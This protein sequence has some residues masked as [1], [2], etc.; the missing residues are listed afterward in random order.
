MKD[1][2]VKTSKRHTYILN[3]TLLLPSVPPKALQL[4]FSKHPK[5]VIWVKIHLSL[6]TSTSLSTV[7]RKPLYCSVQSLFYPRGF[8]EWPV[9]AQ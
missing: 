5:G 7:L 1:H 8:Q 2:E 3:T 9:A 4:S 6:Y